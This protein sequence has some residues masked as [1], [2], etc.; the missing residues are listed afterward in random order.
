MPS[1][2]IRLPFGR[3]EGSVVSGSGRGSGCGLGF[4]ADGAADGAAVGRGGGGA[5]ERRDCGRGFAPLLGPGCCADLG[6]GGGIGRALLGLATGV[7]LAGAG[8][9]ST[10]LVSSSS[11][12]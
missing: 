9:A 1:S 2:A 3:A 12:S 7:G 11:A 6:S 5:A 4:L 8:S 10:G